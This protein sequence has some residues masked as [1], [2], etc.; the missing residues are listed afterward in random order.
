M[1]NDHIML[2][3][4][5]LSPKI[6]LKKIIGYIHSKSSTTVISQSKML[7]AFFFGP[8]AKRGILIMVTDQR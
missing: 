4:G 8:D 3:T 7:N 1:E 5:K 2:N 6:K